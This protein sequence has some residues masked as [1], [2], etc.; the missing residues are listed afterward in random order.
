MG[1]FTI[2]GLAAL[3]ALGWH[4]G[5]AAQDSLPSSADNTTT[6]EV[7]GDR[8][9]RRDEI[10]R[11]QRRLYET[12]PANR[13][14]PRFHDP[15]CVAVVGLEGEQN[16]IV[17]ERIRDNIGTAGIALAGDQCKPNAL[18]AVNRT[19]KA[20]IGALRARDPQLFNRA[21]EAAIRRQLAARKPAIS[22]GETILRANDGILFGERRTESLNPDFAVPFYFGA[23]P[24]RHRAPLYPAKVN[25]IVVFDLDRLEDVHVNQLADYATLHL[26]GD[27]RDPA[28]HV[29]AGVPTIL[30]LF[31]DGPNKTPLEMT[32]LDRAYLRGLYRMGSADWASRL[33]GKVLASYEKPVAV[34]DEGSPSGDGV[35]SPS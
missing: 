23:R 4:G 15:V 1:R 16:A 18:V 29:A 33:T 27:P 26:V 8:E 2:T 22:W 7:Q 12:A 14:A 31:A 28:D 25:A 30:S 17:A 35:P 3:G 10:I 34:Q 21:S 20:L 5:I 24:S 32:S 11:G 19:P 13:A 9:L 6:I